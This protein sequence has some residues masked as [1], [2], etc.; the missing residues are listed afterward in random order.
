MPPWGQ[1]AA[2]QHDRGA[3]PERAFRRADD[4]L[5][6]HGDAGQVLPD[7]T[8]GDGHRGRLE[9]RLELLH[10]AAG[11]A[12]A[13]DRDLDVVG[14]QVAG[15]QDV[16]AAVPGAGDEVARRRGAHLE[17]H[18]SGLLDGPPGAAGDL[19]QVT[20]ADGQLGGG[21]HDCDLGLDHVLVG[22][23]ER[24]PLRPPGRPAGRPRLEVAAQ[25]HERS[26]PPG[27]F[28]LD[29]A[30]GGVDPDPVAG[31]DDEAWVPVQVGQGGHPGD[32]GT[33]GGLGADPGDDH[34]GRRG[35]EQPG[36]LEEAGPAGTSLGGREDQ[37]LAGE[38]RPAQGV[39]GLDDRARGRVDAAPAGDGLGRDQGLPLGVPG[40]D[41]AA[42]QSDRSPW[43]LSVSYMARRSAGP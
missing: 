19:V 35:A 24:P 7:G 14:D 4:L 21:V 25:G 26:A 34:G 8:A 17:A 30:V 9:Q 23:P 10:H 1:A 13:L 20:E 37:D 42:V 11:A 27:R 39:P 18:P 12:G 41:R 31:A 40:Y 36:A 29:Q 28:D 33:E 15:G 2:D 38:G 5:I 6:G 3:V 22:E 16:P 32:D 43:E